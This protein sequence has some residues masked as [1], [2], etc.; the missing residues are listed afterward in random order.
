MAVRL[1]S[2]PAVLDAW[3]TP[4]AL[5]DGV[6]RL[7]QVNAAWRAAAPRLPA[8]DPSAASGAPWLS[9]LEAGAAARVQPVLDDTH[10][11]H[12]ARVELELALA[13]GGPPLQARVATIAGGGAMLWL[14]PAFDA[15]AARPANPLVPAAP[16]R[17][18]SD[19]RASM[20]DETPHIAVQTYDT[21][22]RITWWNGAAQRLY[23]FALDEVVGRRPSELISDR[24]EGEKFV[25]IL[26]H[27]RRSGAA[28]GPYTWA[29][30][31]RDGRA[32]VAYSTV[33]PTTDAGEA[34]AF[35]GMDVDVSALFH[36]EAERR[37][38]EARLL[39]AQKMEGLG[40]L[41]GGI[42]H[43]F[44]N[45]LTAILGSVELA[46]ADA[47]TTGETRELLDEVTAAARRAHELT[48]QLL[49]FARRP[50]R[51]ANRVIDVSEVLGDVHRLLRRLIG[52]DVEI[53]AAF[54]PELPAVRVDPGQL[55]QLVVNLAV[56]ARDAM[57][58]GGRL[59]IDARALAPG[60]D[61]RF[62]RGAARIEVADT[63]T[64]MSDEVKARLFEPFFTTKEPGRGTGLGLATCYGIVN[65][66]G[67][68]I[69]CE[70]T[71]GVGTRFEVLL[72]ASSSPVTP[73]ES[74]DGRPSVGGH[75]RVLLVEDEQLVR[76]LV[77]AVLRRAGYSLLVAPGPVEAIALVEAA[78]ARGEPPVTLLV[79]DVVMPKL[80]GAALAARL[81]EALPEL[82]ILL[83]SGY[84]EDLADR[85]LGAVPHGFIAKPFTPEELLGKVRLVL[86]A[87]DDPLTESGGWRAG[88][89]SATSSGPTDGRTGA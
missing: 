51:V 16:S 42:A 60:D 46:R 81:R 37:R 33:F 63:G 1:P 14:L 82:K 49:T 76:D 8:L 69:A 77:E 80:S 61:P 9:R 28:Y 56:N 22:G 79:A 65:Q 26:A 67:G 86:D 88:P 35:V 31:A 17:T 40:R 84:A 89:A 44:N 32:G 30:R 15:S 13:D 66:A 73:A 50:Q 78:R 72:P 2:V 59:T 20:V 12:V 47:G 48:T 5:V 10:P 83:M 19:V 39:Q 41:A 45:L 27:V 4:T 11:E 57:P 53:V 68:A 43:D 36:A 3:P 23:G 6:G 58:T 21:H 52:E 18:W 75:E 70:S 62:P 74:S 87:L 38:L 54:A 71:A 25:G 85:E 7:M 24:A 55:E 64:G 34:S 29:Y